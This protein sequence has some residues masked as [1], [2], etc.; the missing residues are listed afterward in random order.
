MID[1][2]FDEEPADFT[3]TVEA[4]DYPSRHR[5]ELARR[6]ASDIELNSAR[7]DAWATHLPNSLDLAPVPFY[8]HPVTGRH[9]LAPDPELVELGRYLRRARH[10]AHKSQ[11][12]V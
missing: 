6:L 4:P 11:Q 1:D 3:E 12:R 2:D 5:S 9:E 7:R 10:L 8:R